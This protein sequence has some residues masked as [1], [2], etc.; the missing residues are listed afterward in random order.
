VIAFSRDVLQAHFAAHP[1]VGYT[2]CLNL[3]TIVGKRLHLFQAMWLR[4]MQRT[5]EVRCA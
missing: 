2:I 1:A 3:S 4:E 5:V